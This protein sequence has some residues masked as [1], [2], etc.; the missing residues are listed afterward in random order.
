MTTTDTTTALRDGA[1]WG[2]GFIEFH[3]KNPHIYDI[4]VQVARDWVKRTGRRRCGM[5]LIYSL[6]RWE[7]DFD[8]SG[9]HFK[10]ND[11]YQSYYAR[12]IMYR[13]PDLRDVFEFRTSPADTFMAANI[14]RCL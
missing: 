1:R 11:G 10:L 12:L 6:A 2:E 9:S 8:S 3:N 4:L 13:E 7:Y 14:H 5:T